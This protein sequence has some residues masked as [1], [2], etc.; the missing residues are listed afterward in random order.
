MECHKGFDHFSYET[1]QDINEVVPWFHAALMCGQD[2]DEAQHFTPRLFKT[3]QLHLGFCSNFS[4]LNIFL[5]VQEI[6]NRTHVSRTPKKPE[7][8]I[9]RSQLTERGPLGFGPIQFVM[10]PR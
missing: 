5:L 2:L 4:N 10:D 6:S 3:H 1:A 9:A 8:L 7:Y